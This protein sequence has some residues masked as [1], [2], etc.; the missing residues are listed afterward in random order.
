MSDAPYYESYIVIVTKQARILKYKSS[1]IR[2]MGRGCQ[3]IQAIKLRDGDEIASAF[4][5]EEEI[6]DRK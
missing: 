2:H 5:V 4:S 3:G 6:Y 1:S